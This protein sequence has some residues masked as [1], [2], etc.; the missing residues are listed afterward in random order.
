MA[1]HW[2]LNDHPELKQGKTM[3]F[4]IQPNG[5][6]L[7][8]ILWQVSP[9]SNASF[10]MATNYNSAV[11]C[12]KPEFSFANYTPISSQESVNRRS[13]TCYLSNV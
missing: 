11:I 13:A 3:I 12:T 8:R 7:Y 2:L 9:S 10:L 5:G 4:T 6:Y 1:A